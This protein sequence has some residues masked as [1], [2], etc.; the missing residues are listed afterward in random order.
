M[1]DFFSKVSFVIS[2]TGE[3]YRLKEKKESGI[4]NSDIYK[5][6][7]KTSTKMVEKTE[8]V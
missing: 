1:S 2:D 8:V 5:F 4:L 7:V 6:G 3:S